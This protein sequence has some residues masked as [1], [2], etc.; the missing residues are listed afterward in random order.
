MSSSPKDI[1]ANIA[2]VYLQLHPDNEPDNLKL[3]SLAREITRGLKN[4][5]DKADAVKTYIAQNCKY[6]LQAPAAPRDRDIVEYF[7]FDSHQGYCDKF[8]ASMVML[9]RYAG[10]PA[11]LASGFLPGDID[12]DQTYIVREK[13]KHLWAQVFFPKTGW[14]MFDATD[15]ADDITAHATQAKTKATGFLNWLVSTGWTPRLIGAVILLLLV[16]LFKTEVLD[17]LRP[18]RA[19]AGQPDARPQ[20]NIEVVAAYTAACQALARRGLARP[21]SM[22]PDEYRHWV[23]LRASEALPGLQGPLEGL[24]AQ[25]ARFRYGMETATE[26]DVAA[27]REAAAAISAQLAQAKRRAFLAEPVQAPAV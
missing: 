6:N 21:A 26:A 5:Y 15:G 3:R 14:V 8:A 12:K 9:C 13:H 7:L 4:N 11:R 16:Y 23:S 10:I 25:H 27:A 24:T 19:R 18:Q 1:P 20:T 17:R 2:R 22:T